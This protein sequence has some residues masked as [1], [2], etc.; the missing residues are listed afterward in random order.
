MTYT[1]K[2]ITSSDDMINSLDIIDRIENLMEMRDDE[3]PAFTDEDAKELALLEDFAAQVSPYCPD[4]QYGE[5][6]IRASYFLDYTMELIYDAYS[7]PSGWPFRCID[8]QQAADELL[9]DY[10]SATFDGVTY[11]FR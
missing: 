1:T 11:Y 6:I 9:I 7:V 5:Q 4:W 8:W 10:T 3:D 2:E